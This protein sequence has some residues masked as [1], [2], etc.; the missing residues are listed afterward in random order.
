MMVT[1]MTYSAAET[2]L[3][4]RQALGPIRAWDDCLADMR[5]GKTSVCDLVLMPA[6]QRLDSR[7]WRP[8]YAVSAIREFIVEVAKVMPDLK[9]KLPPQGQV[10]EYD[11]NISWRVQKIKT[12]AT[13]H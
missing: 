3:I 2:A 11:D 5:A 1:E 8:S 12:P 9:V 10:I 7:A 13:V 4:L 6:I